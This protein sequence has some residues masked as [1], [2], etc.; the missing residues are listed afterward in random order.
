MNHEE[1]LPSLVLSPRSAK[2]HSGLPYLTEPVRSAQLLEQF[3]KSLQALRRNDMRGAFLKV[4]CWRI[5]V[6]LRV[7]DLCFLDSGA[8]MAVSL[9][10]TRRRL[11]APG[12]SIGQTFRL[13]YWLCTVFSHSFSSAEMEFCASV[14]LPPCAAFLVSELS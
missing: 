1:R 5:G 3:S 6:E 9:A 11:R 2:Q 12:R 14:C 4:K 8:H 10:A 7:G 13:P